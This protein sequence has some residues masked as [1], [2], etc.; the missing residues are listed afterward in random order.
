MMPAHRV[1]IPLLLL[2]TVASALPGCQRG[3][4]EATQPNIKVT[5]ATT[6]VIY[7]GLIAV[8][9]ER[10]YFR[11][12]GL[13]VTVIS[14]FP[15]GIASMQALG[16]GEADLATGSDFVF[17]GMMAQGGTLRILASIGATSDHE[18]IARRDRGIGSPADLAGKRVGI[19]K[20]TVSEYALSMFLQLNGID[21]R[22]LT[23]VEY[24]VPEVTDALARGEVDSVSMWGKFSFQARERLGDNAIAWPSQYNLEFQ[25]VLAAQQELLARSPEIPERLLR[26][27]KRAEAF[28]LANQGQAREIITRAWDLDPKFVEEFWARNKLRVV[29]DQSLAFSLES[30]IRWRSALE[31]EPLD[32]PNVV[33]WIDQEPLGRV[34]PKSVTIIAG[35]RQ[36]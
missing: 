7:T 16:R 1:I 28:V 32:M 22:T 15:A 5:L 24:E 11:E 19:V 2:F 26:A 25:W 34:D 18:I 21:H 17:T 3:G 13:D 8:A 10:G 20:D 33:G 29:L 4:P 31:G 36:G 12:A 23:L 30:S 14:D 6:P 35:D 27:L 9:Q